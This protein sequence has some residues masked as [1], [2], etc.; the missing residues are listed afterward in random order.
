MAKYVGF[1]IGK[2]HE[3]HVISEY[4]CGGCGYPVTDHDS[5]CPE[6]GGA[7]RESDA[8]DLEAENA[9]LRD[10]LD[11]AKHD[12][13]LFSERIVELGAENAELRE[14]CESLFRL[15]N[16]ECLGGT[17]DCDDCPMNRSEPPC[18]LALDFIAMRKLGIDVTPLVVKRV[19]VNE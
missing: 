19:E 17:R 10:K 3:S 13:S 2:V 8:S 6:C 9:K 14:L 18:S 12:L 7:F 16:N 11:A 4:Y 5:F 1:K 15:A